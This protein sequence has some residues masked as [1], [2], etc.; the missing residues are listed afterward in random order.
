MLHVIYENFE[1]RERSETHL[2]DLGFQKEKIKYVPSM[3]PTD[4]ERNSDLDISL[5]ENDYE[6]CRI[7][8]AR[9]VNHYQIWQDLLKDQDHEY[10]NILEDV[11]LVPAA[12]FL[13]QSLTF[14]DHSVYC[15]ILLYGYD[16]SLTC[17][18]KTKYTHPICTEKTNAESVLIE[19]LNV[20]Q[21]LGGFHAYSINKR[22]AQMMCDYIRKNGLRHRIDLLLQ[23]PTLSHIQC[24]ETRPFLILPPET[25]KCLHGS[26]TV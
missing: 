4:L 3:D 7:C 8:I 25:T 16:I 11:V 12:R 21:Y 22:G 24:S 6:N 2:R 23:L 18:D 14:Q 1:S 5:K 9:A 17:K 26:S 13:L 19:N 10:Y 15:D 20:S